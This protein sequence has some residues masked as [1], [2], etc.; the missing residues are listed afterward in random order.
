[1]EMA[2]S[3]KPAATT[4]SP[5]KKALLIGIDYNG[6][7]F[8]ETLDLPH[9]DVSKLRQFLIDSYGY[10]ADDITLMLDKPGEIQP[11]TAN[12]RKQAASLVADAKPEDHFFFYYAG[13]SAQVPEVGTEHTELDGKDE[14]MVTSDGNTS[15][16][17][18]TRQSCLVDDELKRLLV[19]PLPEGATLM[20]V[21]DTCHSASLLDL[22]HNTC[23]QKWSCLRGQSNNHPIISLHNA[24]AERVSP[25]PAPRTGPRSAISRKQELTDEAATDIANLRKSAGLRLQHTAC[26]RFRHSKKAKMPGHLALVMCLSACRDDQVTCENKN[27][28]NG[29]SFTERLLHILKDDPHPR[30]E[31]LMTKI[32]VSIHGMLLDSG[33]IKELHNCQDPQMSS[34][35]ELDMTAYLETL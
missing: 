21:L 29:A 35:R 10:S 17:T 33:N 8:E 28:K 26:A 13:H 25:K 2:V 19:C 14:V 18:L 6:C 23:N 31:D 22:D 30:L 7:K 24:G 11:T 16:D 34:E 32:S 15:N 1:M 5:K 20:A 4:R 3:Q 9:G 12:I 27:D